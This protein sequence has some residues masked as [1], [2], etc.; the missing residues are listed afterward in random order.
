MRCSF[1]GN[2]DQNEKYSDDE[3]RSSKYSFATALSMSGGDGDNSYSTNSLLQVISSSMFF[4]S[5]LYMQKLVLQ[6]CFSSRSV[7]RF[8]FVVLVES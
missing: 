4:L 1:N 8:N 7:I 6:I 3:E 2:T 5:F